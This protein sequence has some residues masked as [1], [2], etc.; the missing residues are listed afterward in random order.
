MLDSAL[1]PDAPHKQR[2]LILRH[3]ESE[4][5]VE[6][7]WQ[8]WLDAPLTAEGE[9]QAALRAR[10]L[11][12]NGVRPRAVYSS[13][14]G[15]ARRTA[16]IVA[17]HLDVPILTDEG[18]RERHGGDWQ[19]HTGDEIDAKWPGMRERWR[20]G[21]LTAPPGGEEDHAV[22]ARFD[23]ALAR[24]L[25]HV[26]SNLLVIVTHHGVLRLVATRAGMDVH[27]LIPNLGG[28]WFDVEHAALGAPE[29]LGPVM[30]NGE[31]AALE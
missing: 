20:N 25:R 13:D 29:P 27:A 28:Y 5:N 17:A 26:G 8:G 2:V 21:E 23:A 16:E 4:W 6:R 24:A 19:G 10:A 3:G 12:H 22:L 9:H 11:A 31:H 14:L 30:L 1:V 15:R 18:F 7:R